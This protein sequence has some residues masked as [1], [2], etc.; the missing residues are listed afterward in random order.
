MTRYLIEVETTVV[1]VVAVKADSEDEAVQ[2]VL[3]SDVEYYNRFGAE[4]LFKGHQIARTDLESP[5]HGAASILRVEEWDGICPCNEPSWIPCDRGSGCFD[6]E[7]CKEPCQSE[8]CGNCR[9]SRER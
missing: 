6:D 9:A 8:I 2:K 1:S 5:G 7:Q 3:T 4:D